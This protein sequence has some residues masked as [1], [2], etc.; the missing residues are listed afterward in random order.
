MK[1]EYIAIPEARFRIL[2]NAAISKENILSFLKETDFGK[3]IWDINSKT[4]HQNEAAEVL[5]TYVS[6]WMDKIW[7]SSV[8]EKTISKVYSDQ[9]LY[10]LAAD[11]ITD[12]AKSVEDEDERLSEIRGIIKFLAAKQCSDKGG[13][14]E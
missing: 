13:G 9:D 2:W 6:Q 5:S 4:K 1:E 10:I 7:K 14:C 12:I 3:Y 8:D 11:V